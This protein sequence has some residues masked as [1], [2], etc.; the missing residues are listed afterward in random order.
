MAECKPDPFVSE[1]AE[2]EVDE[3]TAVAIQRGIQAADDGQVV[4][5]EEARE[6]MKQWISELSTP[7]PR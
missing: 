7:A 1:E 2:I 3:S 5:S 4:S 6:H